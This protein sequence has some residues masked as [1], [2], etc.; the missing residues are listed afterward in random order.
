VGGRGEEEGE[1]GRETQCY[2]RPGPSPAPLILG[3]CL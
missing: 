3:L 2:P 1:E